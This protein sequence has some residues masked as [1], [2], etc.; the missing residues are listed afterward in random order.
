MAINTENSL[1]A[2]EGGCHCGA[3]RFEIELKAPVQ[4]F[5]CN[6]SICRKSGFIHVFLTPERFH[7]LRGQ[8][9]LLE[10]R[11][12]TGTARHLFC[13][14]CGVKSYYV[15]R[16]H[17]DGISVNLNCLDLPESVE[18]TIGDFDGANWSRSIE[19]LH[20]VGAESANEQ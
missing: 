16:S 4:A 6:C 13:R 17:P 11:F 14:Y 19:G 7:L 10:Y 3:V 15:P 1:L 8:D 2:C 5:R 20:S 9:E 12:H 18:L